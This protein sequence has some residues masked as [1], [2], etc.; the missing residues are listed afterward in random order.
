MGAGFESQW[1]AAWFRQRS[2]T[3]FRLAANVLQREDAEGLLE[4]ARDFEAQAVAAEALL[5]AVTAQRS[6]AAELSINY[7][8]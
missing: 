8:S 7:R 1:D 2:A 3:C 6:A 4:L 5:L